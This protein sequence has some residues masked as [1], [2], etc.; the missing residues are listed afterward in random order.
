MNQGSNLTNFMNPHALD[1]PL[2]IAGPVREPGTFLRQQG[3][4][5]GNHDFRLTKAMQ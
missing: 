2:D 5:P 4:K 1:L 3:L